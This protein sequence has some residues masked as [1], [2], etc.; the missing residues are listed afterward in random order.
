MT[1]GKLVCRLIQRGRLQP[2]PLACG[3]CA[4]YEGL[5]CISAGGGLKRCACPRGERLAAL[6]ATRKANTRHVGSRVRALPSDWKA[7]A[8]GERA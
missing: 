5:W 7:M 1:S 6:D 3:F 2:L 4:P 8:A